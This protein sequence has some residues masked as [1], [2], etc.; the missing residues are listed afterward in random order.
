MNADLRVEGRHAPKRRRGCGLT[1]S[2]TDVRVMGGGHKGC[3]KAGHDGSRGAIQRGRCEPYRAGPPADASG[4]SSNSIGASLVRAFSI[5][6]R[7]ILEATPPRAEKPPV[8]PPAA[9]TRWQGTII[10]NG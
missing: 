5:E 2:A 10:G 9:N 8:L 3:T 7:R 6:S 1:A 4:R